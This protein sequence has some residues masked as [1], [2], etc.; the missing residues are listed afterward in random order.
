MREFVT[1]LAI[2]EGQW[3][4]DGTRITVG[5]LKSM[6]RNPHTG[7]NWINKQYPWLELTEEEAEAALR[8]DIPPIHDQP[9]L[10]WG[11]DVQ[12]VRCVCGNEVIWEHDLGIV[13]SCTSCGRKYRLVLEEVE[14]E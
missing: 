1:S 6:L 5:Q 12:V 3:R 9:E 14:T 4:L 11:M 2:C 7:F 8:F 13:G 10:Y